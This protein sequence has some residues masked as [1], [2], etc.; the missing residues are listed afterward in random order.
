LQHTPSTQ[1]AEA[2]SSSLPQTIPLAL[3][4]HLPATHCCPAAH[5]TSVAQLLAQRLVVASQL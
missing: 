5:W 1:K 3:L 2:Q 4:P